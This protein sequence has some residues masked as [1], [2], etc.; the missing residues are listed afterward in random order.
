M[1]VRRRPL[2]WESV[3]LMLFHGINGRI[4]V[5][6]YCCDPRFFAKS[7]HFDSESGFVQLHSPINY[8]NMWQ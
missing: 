2:V 1:Y 8:Y 6:L 7:S 3:R 5:E 4:C